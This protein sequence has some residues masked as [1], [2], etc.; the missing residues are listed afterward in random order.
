MTA[1][2]QGSRRRF[3]HHSLQS[4]AGLAMGSLLL[5]AGSRAATE[6]RFEL[7]IHQFS[8]KQ[9]LNNGTLD[10]SA[11]PGFVKEQ[12]GFSSVEFAVDFCGSLREN[13]EKGDAIRA[14][15]KRLGVQHRACSAVRTPRSIAR[16]KKGV[17]PRFKIT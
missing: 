1:P 15:S 17:R 16:P 4:A 7:S 5:P 3:L 10:T 11:Y 14:N 8:L 6:K 2:H 13:P 12:F 9:L